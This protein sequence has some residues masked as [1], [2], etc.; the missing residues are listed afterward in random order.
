MSP[1]KP[2]VSVI[3]SIYNSQ[4]F[5][6]SFLEDVERQTIFEQSEILLI[7][8]GSEHKRDLAACHDFQKKFPSN[9]R[10]ILTEKCG[11]YKAWNLGIKEASS[12]LLANWNTDDRRFFDSLEAQVLALH[13]SPDVDLVYGPTLTTYVENEPAHLCRSE[14]RFGCYDATI[15]NMLLNNSPHCLPV[16]RASLHDRFGTFDE[17]YRS[18]GDYEMWMRAL[19]GG[20]KFKRLD[21]LIGTYYRNPEGIS[22]NPLGYKQA[23]EEVFKVRKIYG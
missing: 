4:R 13:R 5:I 8:C 17:S 21:R 22:S 14:E 16:W 18:A 10:V 6:D 15:E 11:L 2:L 3:S 23:L 19:K 12:T 7:I 1:K 20:A 9:A